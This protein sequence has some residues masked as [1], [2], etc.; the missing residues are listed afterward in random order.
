MN[1]VLHILMLAAATTTPSPCQPVTGQRIMGSDLAAASPVFATL[2][3]DLV[4]GFA[5]QPGSQ[6]VFTSPEL[7]RIAQANGIGANFPASICFERPTAPLE[8]PDVEKA[9]RDSGIGDVQIQ[10]V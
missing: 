4:A 8:Q 1:P 9:M 7:M 10:I 3:A 2:P 6:R 5:P